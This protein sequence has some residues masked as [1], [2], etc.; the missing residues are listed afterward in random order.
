[1]TNRHPYVAVGIISGMELG[2]RWDI[3]YSTYFQLMASEVYI[4]YDNFEH[5][6]LLNR[7]ILEKY[8]EVQLNQLGT[9]TFSEM[10]LM[11]FS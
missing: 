1:M 11:I 6:S 8:L 4:W 5:N 7:V 2:R 10:F 9:K 3:P